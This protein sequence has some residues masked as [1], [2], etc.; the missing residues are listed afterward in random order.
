MWRCLVCGYV[1]DGENAPKNCPKCGSPQDKFEKIAKED[2]NK[3]LRSRFSND[4][5]MQLSAQ[6]D[7]VLDIA[8]AGIEDDL[9]PGCVVVFK[10][11]KEEALIIKQ[12]I[13]A[14]IGTHI[15][16]GKWS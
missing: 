13:K 5:H 14:E 16:K 7:V 8:E 10:K 9:D 3:I 1:H 11:A 6:L 15:S 12:M 4:L 2:E